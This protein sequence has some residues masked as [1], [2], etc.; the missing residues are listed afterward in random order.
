MGKKNTEEQL[1]KEI[2]ALCSGHYNSN[3]E[4]GFVGFKD[5]LK[6]RIKAK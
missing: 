6:P 4:K 1:Q 3:K 2:K 5:T